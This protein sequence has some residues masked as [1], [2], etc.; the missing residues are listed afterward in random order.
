MVVVVVVVAQVACWIV[1]V[2]EGLEEDSVGWLESR[3]ATWV[4]SV[5]MHWLAYTT[6]LESASTKGDCRKLAGCDDS[7]I[8]HCQYSR[9]AAASRRSR[10]WQSGATCHDAV[11]VRNEVKADVGH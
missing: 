6:D 2:T 4:R 3:V 5:H 11:R 1:V 8:A 10:D 9:D 7:D